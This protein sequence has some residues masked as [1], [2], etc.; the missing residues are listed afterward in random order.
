MPRPPAE[1]GTFAAYRRHLRNEEVVDEACQ[2]AARAEKAGRRAKDREAEIVTV[3]VSSVSDGPLDEISELRRM[4]KVLTEHMGEAPPQS[5]AAI[6]R[7]ADAVLVRIKEIE[8]GSAA[9]GG[10]LL[11]GGTV[12]S[13]VPANVI[14]FPGARVANG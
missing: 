8:G 9:S 5:I 2:E 7:Q 12:P 13:S 10:G 3:D 14:G 11:S 6:V 4:Y 1:C